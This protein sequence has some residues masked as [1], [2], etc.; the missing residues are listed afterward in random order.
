[1]EFAGLLSRCYPMP[2]TRL[3]GEAQI[4]P[5]WT[6][7]Q[8]SGHIPY[9]VM[10]EILP[11]QYICHKPFKDHVVLKVKVM[12]PSGNII[13]WRLG[14]HGRFESYDQARLFPGRFVEVRW[15]AVE[16]PREPEDIHTPEGPATSL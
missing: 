16:L 1:M 13:Q 9:P 2:F 3:H 14:Q 15:L 7:T 4:R 12:V 5:G 11:I 8:I 10:I 6:P